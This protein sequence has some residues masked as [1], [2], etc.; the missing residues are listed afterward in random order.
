MTQSINFVLLVSFIL[1][2]LYAQE[3]FSLCTVSLFLHSYF[4]PVTYVYFI[5]LKNYSKQCTYL[6]FTVTVILI[7]IFFILSTLLLLVAI[8]RTYIA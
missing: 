1:L 2:L 4:I 6:H 7:K 5:N 3:T 8:L